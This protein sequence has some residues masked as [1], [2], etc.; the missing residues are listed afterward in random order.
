[1]DFSDLFDN[2]T[3]LVGVK[4]GNPVFS[5]IDTETT[6]LNKRY[7]RVI[8]LA[9]ARFDV[10]FRLVDQ[11]HTLLNPD[12]KQI[13]NSHLHGITDADVAHAPT[14][15]EVFTE[16]VSRIDGTVL[17]AHNAPFDSKMIDA[18]IKRITP[19]NWDYRDILPPYVDSI[20]VAKQV[21]KLRSYSLAALLKHVGLQNLKSHAAIADATAT[22]KMLHRLFGREVKKIGRQ[23]IDQA[24]EQAASFSAPDIYSWQLP[25]RPPLPRS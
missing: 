3:R 10:S 20:R 2:V 7:D 18:E 16:F 9:V 14:F 19:P 21:V 12:G 13:N 8:E 5:I 23:I 4:A 1:M 25:Q 17:L 6:G 15:G 22:G 11:W 24:V